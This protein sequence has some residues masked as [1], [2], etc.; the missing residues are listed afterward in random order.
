M[1]D[2]LTSRP[3]DF[4]RGRVGFIIQESE[5]TNQSSNQGTEK[6]G[7]GNFAQDRDMASDAG[8]K[9]GEHSQGGSQQNQGGSHG[10]SQQGHTGAEHKQQ[11]GN[12]AQNPDRAADAGRKGGQH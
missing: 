8:S 12:L 9:G 6:G 2:L 5:M 7:S 4:S 3:D 1:P 11:G 10:G